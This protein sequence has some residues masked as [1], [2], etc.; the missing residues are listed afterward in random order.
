ML[1]IFQSG[2]SEDLIKNIL[3]IHFRDS[4]VF[5]VLNDLRSTNTMLHECMRTF[6]TLRTI[7][8][9]LPAHFA[10]RT[11]SETETGWQIAQEQPASHSTT[12]LAAQKILASKNMAVVLYLFTRPIYSPVTSLSSPGWKWGCEGWGFFIWRHGGGAVDAFECSVF[13]GHL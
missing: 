10:G 4:S 9:D 6:S 2:R 13:G 12:M 1:G 3:V 7:L 11:Q 8:R 5:N